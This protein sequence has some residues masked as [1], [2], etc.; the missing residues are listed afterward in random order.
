MVYFDKQVIKTVVQRSKFEGV[1]RVILINDL[2][3][4]GSELTTNSVVAYLNTFIHLD[5]AIHETFW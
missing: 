5:T 3:D 1:R 4:T 2:L